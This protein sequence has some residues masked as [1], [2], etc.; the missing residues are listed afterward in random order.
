MK[1]P[2]FQIASV[3][4]FVAIAALEFGA[5]RAMYRLRLGHSR[6]LHRREKTIANRIPVWYAFRLA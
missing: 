4:A 1:G 5:L 3:T 6:L 2:R